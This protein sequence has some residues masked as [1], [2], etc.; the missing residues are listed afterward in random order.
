MGVLVF[1]YKFLVVVRIWMELEVSSQF[2]ILLRSFFFVTIGFVYSRW[3]STVTD[4]GCGQ[5]TFTRDFFS[6][7]SSLCTH[8]IVA[9]G[10]ARR[11]CIKHVHPHV[12]TCLSVCCLLVCLLCLSCHYVFSH[13]YLFSVPNF[14]S[15]DVENAEHKTQ[16]A[17]AK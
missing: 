13:F 14:N 5:N 15:H 3:R 6:T 9:Q 11:L 4:G 8:H 10:V 7:L 1:I 16:S 17:Q 2:F 12:I